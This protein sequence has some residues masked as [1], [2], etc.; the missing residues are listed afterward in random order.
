MHTFIKFEPL[1]MQYQKNSVSGQSAKNKSHGFSYSA[2]Q[3][4]NFKCSIN[5][6]KPKLETK[7]QSGKPQFIRFATFLWIISS[8]CADILTTV[9]INKVIILVHVVRLSLGAFCVKI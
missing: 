4:C 9:F 2:N 1:H 8:S 7:W 5:P 3:N 6:A